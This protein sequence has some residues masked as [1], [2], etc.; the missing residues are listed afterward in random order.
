VKQ[1]RKERRRGEGGERIYRREERG[2]I[3]KRERERER[4]R[5]RAKKGG[6]KNEMGRGNSIEA[7]RAAAVVYS[8]EYR[9]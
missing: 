9:I 3:G 5:E 1:H 6:R 2:A 7:P 4:E 8:R